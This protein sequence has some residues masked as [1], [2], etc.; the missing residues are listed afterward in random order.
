VSGEGGFGRDS[1]SSFGHGQ[2]KSRI[3]QELWAVW[4]GFGMAFVLGKSLEELFGVRGRIK[5]L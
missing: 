4:A 2:A 5:R 3:F 1:S